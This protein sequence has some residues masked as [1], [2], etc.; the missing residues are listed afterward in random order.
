MVIA[1]VLLLLAVGAGLMVGRPREL[2]MHSRLRCFD[3]TGPC[4][5]AP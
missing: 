3:L 5:G 4:G 1:G 2:T